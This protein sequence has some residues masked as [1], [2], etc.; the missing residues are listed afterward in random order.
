MSPKKPAKQTSKQAEG[1][2]RAKPR[3]G[4]RAARKAPISKEQTRLN[5]AL[6]A[7]AVD[8]ESLNQKSMEIL[9]RILINNLIVR[10]KLPHFY[11][12]E[13]A[14]R[15]DVDPEITRAWRI[16]EWPTSKLRNKDKFHCITQVLLRVE[17]RLWSCPPDETYWD[18]NKRLKRRLKELMKQG[19]SH[20][21]LSQYLRI[22]FKTLKEILAKEERK[23]CRPKHCPWTYLK[24]L[25]NA[26]DDLKRKKVISNTVQDRKPRNRDQAALEEH[27]ALER[28]RVRM[29]E[30]VIQPGDRCWNCDASW[31]ALR[32]EGDTEPPERYRWYKCYE[33]E[34]DNFTPL[35]KIE[36][37]GECGTCGRPWPNLKKRGTDAEGNTIRMC[38]ICLSHSVINQKLIEPDGL[39]NL[40]NGDMNALQL[41]VAADGREMEP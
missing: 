26:D 10:R 3:T 34:R 13:E 19:H 21:K 37:Y 39:G 16:K 20:N 11:F 40:L 32:Y 35:P 8:A 31:A 23:R 41:L 25:E 28:A 4:R 2:P 17:L 1:T 5:D 15:A 27:E 9:T 6:Q 29:I 7:Q 22:S 36:M 30:Q 24:V 38:V 14:R 33:C 18:A 12:H